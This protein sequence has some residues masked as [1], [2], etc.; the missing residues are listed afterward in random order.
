MRAACIG[1]CMLELSGLEGGL[2]TRLGFGGDTLNTAV[3]LAR[4]LA[5]AGTVDYVTALGDDPFSDEMLAG[6]AAEGI[7]TDLV[8]RLPGMLPGLYA[9]RN[10]A[11]GERSF[12]YW[13]GEAAVRRLLD[14]GRDRTLADRLAGHRLLYLSGITLA[15]FDDEA[16]DRLLG[17]LD[18]VAQ[19]GCAIA[20]DTNYRERLWPSAAAARTAMERVAPHCAFL[21]PSLE[22]DASLFGR[23]DVATSV[24]RWQALGAREIVVRAGGEGCLVASPGAAAIPVE[25]LQ[26]TRV[27]DTT[28]AGD[29]FNGAYLAARLRGE[30][31]LAAARRAHAVAAHVI[32]HGGAIVPAMPAR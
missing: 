7:G 28:A 19:V 26:A 11:A 18:A 6:W 31:Q 4:E 21:L 12:H 22:D 9:I 2:A 3:Y 5:D 29:A 16:R 1:E 27:V 24:R 17:L 23:T 15:I 20:F 13:R 30:G 14:E 25:A 8:F 32:G 10:D